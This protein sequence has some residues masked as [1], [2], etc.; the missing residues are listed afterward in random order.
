MQKREH[1][2]IKN[3]PRTQATVRAKTIPDAGQHIHRST[4][5]AQIFRVYRAPAADKTLPGDPFR[6]CQS[7]S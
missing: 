4:F 7:N 3:W 2:I 1:G 6:F 5:K